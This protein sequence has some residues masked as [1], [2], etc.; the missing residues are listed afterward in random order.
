[1]IHTHEELA[2]MHIRMGA[3]VAE[4]PCRLMAAVGELMA[5]YVRA[6]GRALEAGV[7]FT[8]CS[9]HGGRTLAVG[10][11]AETLKARIRALLALAADPAALA[12]LEAGAREHYGRA[13]ALHY[14]LAVRIGNH[15]FIEFAGVVNELLKVAA[16]REQAG[17]RW[18]GLATFER[19]YLHEKLDCIFSTSLG[20]V[21]SL[22][23][24]GAPAGRVQAG[25]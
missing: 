16:G 9:V 4:R 10:P 20:P 18:Q 25:V 15:A 11:E 5:A 14:A 6:C 19:D 21:S 3:A 22:H 2:R 24:E 12:E 17:D 8:E 1:M 23:A 7:D 13:S